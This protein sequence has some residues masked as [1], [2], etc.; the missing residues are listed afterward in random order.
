MGKNASRKGT[1]YKKLHNRI[2][3]LKTVTMYIIRPI[4]NGEQ[5]KMEYFFMDCSYLE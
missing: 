4:R 2:P 1:I 3:E 5:N